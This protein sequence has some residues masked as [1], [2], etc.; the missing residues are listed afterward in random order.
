MY[1][2]FFGCQNLGAHGGIPVWK[3]FWIR[4]CYCYTVL[5][6]IV[7]LVRFLWSFFH[8]RLCFISINLPCGLAWNT[9]FM[10][11][12]V[13]L[14][15][16]WICRLNYTHRY[17]RLLVQQLLSLLNPWVIV[18]MHPAKGIGITL[19]GVCLLWLNLFCF[20]IL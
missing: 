7:A 4:H 19:V 6:K 5:K 10:S 18:E 20:L 16:T 13:L 9:A 3:S 17:V 11:G 1:I 12:L 15:A 14:A 2:S 8:L